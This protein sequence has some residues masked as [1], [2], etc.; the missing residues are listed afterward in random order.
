[1]SE[2]IY[3]HTIKDWWNKNIEDFVAQKE[4]LWKWNLRREFLLYDGLAHD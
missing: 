1:M 4:E 3:E 2:R